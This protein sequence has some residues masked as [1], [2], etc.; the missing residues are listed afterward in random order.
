MLLVARAVGRV[1]YVTA[2]T[3]LLAFGVLPAEADESRLWPAFDRPGVSLLSGV[4]RCGPA[5]NDGLSEGS[6][7]LTGWAVNQLLLDAAVRF[8]TE[9]GRAMFGEHFRIVNSLSY[10]PDGSGLGGGL[11][12]VFPF[13]SSTFLGAAPSE[14]SAFFLQQGMTRWVD[15]RGTD[16]NDLRFGAVRRF[17]LSEEGAAPGIL[18]LSTFVQQSLEFEHTRLVAGA[19]YAGKWGRGSLNLLCPHDGLAT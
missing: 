18:G 1:S 15:D 3:M 19:D 9:Q 6:Q 7:C 13:A 10:S 11:D 16:R 5:L 4:Q 12:V 2:L 14:F 8:A 17:G